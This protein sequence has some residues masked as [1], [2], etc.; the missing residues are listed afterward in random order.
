MIITVLVPT[1]RRTDDLRRCLEALKKQIR[2][3]DEVIVV[4]RDTDSQTWELLKEYSTGSLPLRPVTVDVPGVI[5]AMNAGLAAAQGEIIALTD[6]DAAPHRDWLQRI[7]AHFAADDKLAVVG[8]RDWMYINNQ[9]VDGAR[10]D[11]GKLQWWGRLVGNHHLGAGGPREVDFVKGVNSS[12]RTEPLRRIGGFDTRLRGDG[13]AVHWE[14]SLGL[15]L[16]RAGWRLLYDP[17]VAVDHYPAPRFDIDQRNKFNAEAVSN[18]VHNETL[19]VLNYL[20]PIRRPIYL[21]W[22]ALLGTG[23]A[24]G[25]LQ[26][27]RLLA[28]RQPNAFRRW[29]AAIRGR[30]A[31]WQTFLGN[32]RASVRERGIGNES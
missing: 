19:C 10:A 30:V 25:V 21:V 17:A 7:E 31:G 6:D 20:P 5:T 4:A 2:P 24:P 22:T 9:L 27:P 8:G 12:Y 18:M 16:K 32:E 1:Y 28:Q 26:V 11:V 14:I 13:A 15:T 3:A 23:E 29:R